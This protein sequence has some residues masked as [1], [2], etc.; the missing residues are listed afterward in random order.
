MFRRRIHRLNQYLFAMAT[1]HDSVVSAVFVAMAEV[2]P[3]NRHVISLVVADEQLCAGFSMQCG[4][5]LSQFF[6]ASELDEGAPLTL[7][8]LFSTAYLIWSRCVVFC[9]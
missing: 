2:C 7:S 4:F 6:S 3:A 1:Q 9:F 5:A 8:G